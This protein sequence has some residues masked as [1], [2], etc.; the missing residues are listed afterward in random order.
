MIWKNAA[1]SNIIFGTW[2]KRELLAEF[3]VPRLTYLPVRSATVLKFGFHRFDGISLGEFVQPLQIDRI[4]II[5]LH[6]RDFRWRIL[7]EDYPVF[8][9]SQ[10]KI[11]GFLWFQF[12]YIQILEIISEFRD[13]LHDVYLTKIGFR[14]FAVTDSEQI[15]FFFF[16]ELIGNK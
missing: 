11:S 2:P 3:S 1:V 16:R 6:D 7:F 10:A 12:F 8:P 13:F 5:Y 15:L 14:N 9:G 4:P